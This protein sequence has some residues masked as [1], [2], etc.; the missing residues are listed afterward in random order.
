MESESRPMSAS[1]VSVRTLTLW[2][3][4][5][6]SPTSSVRSSL[7]CEMCTMPMPGGPPAGGT[8][9]TRAP[10][11]L[12]AMTVPVSHAVSGT[13]SKATSS[14]RRRL[15]SP[16][17][18][19]L[20]LPLAASTLSTRTFTSCPISTSSFTS[21]TKPSRICVMW[22]RPWASPSP[23]FG[24]L[25]STKTPKPEMLATLPV[26]H[27]LLSTSWKRERSAGGPL[28]LLEPPLGPTAFFME[29]PSLPAATST[30]ITRTWTSWPISTSS[31][32][33]STKAPSFISVRWTRPEA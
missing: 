23:P 27:S 17:M 22:T 7:I 13:A 31:V 15:C 6:T 28:I 12:M 2:P 18:E 30:V 21:L 9:S 14:S 29:R 33:S 3:T 20:S 8:T 16:F 25:T 32:T 10:K 5:S 24:G 11:F 4:S 26:S 1:T 19:R